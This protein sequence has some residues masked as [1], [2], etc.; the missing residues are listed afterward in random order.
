[1][2]EQ[3][4]SSGP[5]MLRIDGTK[6]RQLR[7]RQGLTQ[8]YVATAVEVT[9]DT[10]SR[11]E[12]RRYPTIKK[13]NGLKLAAALEVS[14]EDIL[15]APEPETLA[16]P[17][18]TGSA[19][20]AAAGSEPEPVGIGS[21]SRLIRHRR[22][23]LAAAAAILVVTLGLVVRQFFPLFVPGTAETGS[24]SVKRTLPAHFIAGQ[25]FPVFIKVD[26]Q[27]G[28][29]LS[30]ILRETL[31]P[32][33]AIISA[34]P[35][36][37]E[38]QRQKS[39]IQW[40]SKVDGPKLFV[41]TVATSPEYRGTLA[42]AGSLKI[43]PDGESETAIPGDERTGSSTYHWADSDQDN[44]ISDEEI[45]LVYDLADT[46]GQGVIDMELLEEIWLGDGYLWNPDR[47]RFTI[48]DEEAK[49]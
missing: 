8:L 38:K 5:E 15:E 48:I 21:R 6:V 36:L 17:A 2:T 1:M 44:R 49:P 29:A 16:A 43:G 11:W 31:P 30:I 12:N 9:T 13:E 24:L 37:S 4:T 19:P 45:L 39:T 20:G 46:A 25:P 10:V 22:I 33:G 41:Y 40:L 3:I 42:F 34:M 18:E 14:L 7:E 27:P 28:N 32:G 23:W 26:S 47:Q 35:P